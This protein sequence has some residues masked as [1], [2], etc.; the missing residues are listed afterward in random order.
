MTVNNVFYCGEDRTFN[1]ES[2]YV[3]AGHCGSG[4]SWFGEEVK[5]VRVTAQHLVF[6]GV[7]S[8]VEV[9]TKRD[10]LHQVIGKAAKCG[11]GVTARQEPIVWNENDRYES[12]LVLW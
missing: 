2:A 7:K 9:K 3:Y 1:T 5:L 6:R 8:G 11:I 4:H 12:Q 10:N